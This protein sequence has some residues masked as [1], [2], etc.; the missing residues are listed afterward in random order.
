VWLLPFGVRIH[1][2]KEKNAWVHSKFT[3]SKASNFY[4]RIL[5]AWPI[6]FN[7]V[8]LFN[9]TFGYFQTFTPK[10]RN[11]K[12]NLRSDLHVNTLHMALH[13]LTIKGKVCVKDFDKIWINAPVKS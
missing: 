7:F 8:E 12:A 5:Q 3:H 6:E 1:T 13:F 11:N 2:I 10:T 4:I 9:C